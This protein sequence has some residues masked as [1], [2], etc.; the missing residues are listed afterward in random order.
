MDD[1][2]VPG[3]V[4]GAGPARHADGRGDADAAS[5]APRP[6]PRPGPTWHP[7]PR[8][9]WRCPSRPPPGSNTQDWSYLVVTDPKPE[10][11]IAG[12][13][14]AALPD[15]RPARVP[16]PAT[17]RRRRLRQ[18]APGQ[19]QAKHFAEI[20]VFVI[21][22]YERNLKHR[23]VGWP[24]ISVSSFYGSVFPAVQNLLL[25]CRAV[26]L[27]ASLQTLPIWIV[28]IARRILGLRAQV[29]PVCIIPIGWAKGRY[30]PTTRRPVGDVVHLDRYGNQ[31]F[32]STPSA[33]S[34]ACGPG[35]RRPP[36]RWRRGCGVAGRDS[37]GGCS[38]PGAPRWSPGRAAVAHL[39]VAEGHIPLILC[40]PQTR[41]STIWM[42]DDWVDEAP[43]SGT[44]SGRSSR[45]TT[46]ATGRRRPGSRCSA[47][48]SHLALL[49]ERAEAQASRTSGPTP[50][51]GGR[52][53][54]SGST[55]RRATSAP[56]LADDDGDVAV[57]VALVALVALAMP[58]VM[59]GHIPTFSSGVAVRA[60]MGRVTSSM[61]TSTSG[62]RDQVLVPL[63][64]WSWLP[65]LEA[66]TTTR[67]GS[68]IGAV[69]RRPALAART[70]RDVQ[71][72]RL[73]PVDLLGE[74][75]A[76]ELQQC[77]VAVLEHP[78]PH[79]EDR[80]RRLHPRTLGVPGVSRREGGGAV[81]DPF[82]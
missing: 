73:H 32:R 69:R 21:P 45:P 46:P 22:C 65:P 61:V 43:A 48:G 57:G 24:Q 5:G 34:R 17:T 66:T 44:R 20:P 76:A 75:A 68:Q 25:A 51:R 70:T 64:V 38:A 58:P 74:A 54:G 7:A 9:C 6:A 79:S 63:G 12:R 27:G 3:T 40:V 1:F 53:G 77:A 37:R 23:P 81:A 59:A 26:G 14:P 35:D 31:P 50:G 72:E 56:R 47:A 82:P 18:M 41:R 39:P 16:P 28:P 30:G 67:S 36:V 62:S 19:W 80:V 8:V 13:L 33:L 55:W 2:E 52:D 29:A 42:R 10:G 78:G 4:G 49:T 11:A 15:L 71:L 60:R